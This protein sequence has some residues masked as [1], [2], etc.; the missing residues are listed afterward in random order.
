MPLKAGRAALDGRGVQETRAAAGGTITAGTAVMLDAA[1]EMVAADT[2]AGDLY[3]VAVHDD[4]ND[5]NGN[6]AGIAGPF[7]VAADGAVTAGDRVNAGN[8]TGGSTG[9]VI[10]DAAGPAKALSDTGGTWQGY[11]VPA[12]HAVVWFY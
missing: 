12:G 1:G 10:A 8:T 11:T 5:G 7:V 3:G 2:E 4:T 6:S 9:Q